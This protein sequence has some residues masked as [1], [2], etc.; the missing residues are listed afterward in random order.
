MTGAK[1]QPA[2]LPS[3]GTGAGNGRRPR[4][5]PLRNPRDVARALAKV[6]NMVLAGAIEPKAASCFGYLANLIL[7]AH[8]AGQTD[9]RI[10]E[11]ERR[12]GITP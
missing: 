6:A 2:A 8:S 5:L 12:L 10:A 3:P 11:L 9:D 1:I 4:P 7:A